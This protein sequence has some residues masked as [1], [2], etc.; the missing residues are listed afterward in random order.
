MF[1]LARP[2]SYVWVEAK[3]NCSRIEEQDI[4]ADVEVN[5]HFTEASVKLP[6]F[7]SSDLNLKCMCSQPYLFHTSNVKLL[8]SQEGPWL[9]PSQAFSIISIR[10]KLCIGRQ[11]ISG[12]PRC[13]PIHYIYISLNSAK[14]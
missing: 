7:T 14:V 11:P 3:T 4:L 13:N 5:E 8:R 12:L 10:R 1:S 9:I 6:A 2:K